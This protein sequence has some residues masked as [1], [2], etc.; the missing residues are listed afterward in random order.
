MR[1]LNLAARNI[2]SSVLAQFQEAYV[3]EVEAYLAALGADGSNLD[4]FYIGIYPGDPAL[5]VVQR[6]GMV[7][8]YIQCCIEKNQFVVRTMTPEQYAEAQQCLSS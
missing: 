3:Q 1:V 4:R 8:G 7:I 5:Q 6:D 2:A